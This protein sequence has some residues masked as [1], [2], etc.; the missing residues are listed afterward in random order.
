MADQTAE[1]FDLNQFDT[2]W[3]AFRSDPFPFYARFQRERPIAFVPAIG[4]HGMW[5]ATRYHDIVQI[6][7]N[8]AL[9]GRE[10]PDAVGAPRTGINQSLLMLDPPDHTRLRALVSKAFTPRMVERLRPAIQTLAHQLLD[11]VEARGEM[12]LIADFAFPLPAITIAQM[13]GVPTEDLDRFKGWSAALARG[14]G[15]DQAP[16]VYAAREQAAWEIVAFFMGLVEERRANP[17]AD[18]I[19]ELVAIEEQG[20]RLTQQELIT[21][22]VLLLVAGHETTT[23]LIGNGL[24]A[25]LQHPEQLDLLRSRPDLLPVATEELLRFCSPVQ[26]TLRII[27]EDVAF[28]GQQLRRGQSILTIFAAANRDPAVFER[29]Q[30]L[31]ITRTPNPH[32]GFGRGIHFCLGAPLAK[33]EGQIAF[34]ALLERLPGLKLAG[35]PIWNDN[36]AIRGM[37]SLPVKF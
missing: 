21:T 24:L 25:L 18:M 30:E 17:Q 8:D 34:G 13:L 9:F 19:S 3:P 37:S 7:Q 29:P 12:D 10:H 2:R 27:K 33:A 22:L 28:G 14:I 36:A 26:R 15:P 5:M 31:D 32:M 16:E 20:E 6:L 23:N 35:E 1:S 11:Q 4:E